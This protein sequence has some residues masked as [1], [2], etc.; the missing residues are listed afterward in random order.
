M[1]RK[2]LNA[3]IAERFAQR[4]RERMDRKEQRELERNKDY[5]PEHPDNV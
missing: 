4:Q 1:P 5:E 2:S 3:K